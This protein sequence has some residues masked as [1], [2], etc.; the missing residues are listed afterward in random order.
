MPFYLILHGIAVV[1]PVRDNGVY[2]LFLRYESCQTMVTLGK[3]PKSMPV[4]SKTEFI[5][6]SNEKVPVNYYSLFRRTV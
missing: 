4:A 2:H 1:H 3:R 5:I 6:I